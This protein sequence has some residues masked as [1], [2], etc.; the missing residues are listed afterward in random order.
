MMSKRMLQV[1]CMLLALFVFYTL[2][3]FFIA[4]RI[5][6]NYAV[7]LVK[8]EYGRSLAMGEVRVHPFKMYV[9][10]HDVALPDADKSLLCG[11]DRLFV[12]FEVWSSIWQ[13][14]YVFREITLEHPKLH[15]VIRPDGALNLADLIPKASAKEQAPSEK[16]ADEKP[17]RL[18]V[19]GF[20]VANAHLELLDRARKRPFSHVLSPLSFVLRDFRTTADGGGFTLAAT[21][22]GGE[23]LRWKGKVAVAPELSSSGSISLRNV[24]LSALAAYLADDVPFVTERGTLRMTSSYRMRI[25]K[26]L[27]AQVTLP[28]LALEGVAIHARG[29]RATRV[30]IPRLLVSGTKVDVAEQS[31]HVGRVALSELTT[32]IGIEPDGTVNLNRLISREH[33]KRGISRAHAQGSDIPQPAPSEPAKEQGEKLARAGAEARQNTQVTRVS[34][35][36][37]W[38]VRLDAL[39]LEKAQVEVED[40]AVAPGTKVRIAPLDVTVRDLTRELD[41]AVPV[42]LSA[43]LDEDTTLKVEGKVA[44]DP[45]RAELDLDLKNAR[46][47]TAQPYV[48]QHANLMIQDGA[49]DATATVHLG[50]DE[51]GESQLTFRGDATLNNLRTIDDLLRQHFINTRRLELKHIEYTSSPPALA[52]ERVNLRGGYARMVLSRDQ[53]FNVSEVFGASEQTK[54][55]A[56]SRAEPPEAEPTDERITRPSERTNTQTTSVKIGTLRVEDTRVDFADYF[57]KPNFSARLHSLRGTLVGLST[58]PKAN[59]TVSLKGKMG[60]NASVFVKGKLQPLAY[61]KR[62]DMHLITENVELAVFNPY[63]G[64]FAGY[65]IDRGELSSDIHYVLQDRKLTADHKIRIDQLKWGEKTETKGEAPL[66]VKLATVLLRDRHG[67]IELDLPVTGSLDDPKFRLGPIIWQVFKNI[68]VKA[69]T[70]PFAM[71]GKVFKGAEE[72][73]YV[74]FEPGEAVLD[75]R[76]EHGL[77]ALTEA[78]V[79]RRELKLD[80]PVGTVPELDRDAIRE[81]K[82]SMRVNATMHGALR[83]R[84]LEKV[85][86]FDELDDDQKLTV[87]SS[88]YKELTGKEPKLPEAPGAES[89]ASRREA[90]AAKRAFEVSYLERATHEQIKVDDTELDH[91]GQQRGEAIERALLSTGKVDHTRVL[92]SEKGKVTKDQGKVRYELAFE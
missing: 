45:V 33:I 17:P 80:V 40:R 59:A 36:S 25:G 71:L 38:Q 66:P 47:A 68:I 85:R 18:W 78:M 60:E 81:R 23:Q 88:L 61:D 86:G 26:R 46:L 62:T 67:V 72:A 20:E 39:A 24:Q 42:A 32:T 7:T 30:H 11:F 27:E 22:T 75:K 54:A 74:S 37:E 5:V 52:V 28:E 55:K 6:R 77:S 1:L 13:R 41:E 73:K 57:V 10:I 2:F 83:K 84:E 14:A 49:L 64:R 44:V 43:T 70:V 91:L 92:L 31:A 65:N 12:D 69:V 58:D 9:D 4:P 48:A 34:G 35:R 50:P 51:A 90:R 89:G 19:Q 87:L 3:G 21:G 16:R 53:V 56:G 8:Q 82:W 76:A 29:D 15:A 79:D 63:S